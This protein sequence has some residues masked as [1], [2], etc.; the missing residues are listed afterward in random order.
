MICAKIVRNILMQC[1]TSG[2]KISANVV[3]RTILGIKGEVVHR[4]GQQKYNLV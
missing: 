4:A 3:V 1:F 2:I